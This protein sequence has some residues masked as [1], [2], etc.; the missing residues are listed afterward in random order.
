MRLVPAGFPPGLRFVSAGIP[1]ISNLYRREARLYAVYTGGIP[2]Y[3]QSIPARFPSICSLYRQD[4]AYMQPASAVLKQ[5]TA[6]G[7]PPVYIYYWQ[8]CCLHWNMHQALHPFTNYGGDRLAVACISRWNP[9][10][11]PNTRLSLLK[12]C[13]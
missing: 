11:L 12:M 2:A 1:P 9:K 4:S 3:M 10:D 13:I 5:S 6:V 8:D 7:F